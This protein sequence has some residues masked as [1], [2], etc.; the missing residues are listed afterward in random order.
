[1]FRPDI[2]DNFKF[3]VRERRGQGGGGGGRETTAPVLVC[4]SESVNFLYNILFVR[5]LMA[6]Q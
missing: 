1:M 4:Y 3:S 2:I 5:H 6:C